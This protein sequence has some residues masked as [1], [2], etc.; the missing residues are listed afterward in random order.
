MAKAPPQI[1]SDRRRIARRR[2][3]LAMHEGVRF[4]L[5]EVADDMLERL[6]FVRHQPRR[7]LVVGDPAG[8]LGPRLGGEVMQADIAGPGAIALDQPLPAAGFDFIAVFGLLDTVNDLPGA[9]IHLRRALAPGGLA[10]ASFAGAGSL[11]LLRGAMFAAEP[12]RPAARMHPLVDAR[13]GAELLQRTGW[14]D[15]VSDMRELSVGYRT[16]LQLVA[17]LRAACLGNALASPAPPLGRAARARAE[18]AFMGGA[19]RVVE[20]FSILTLSGRSPA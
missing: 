19:E 12:D 16:M 7:S 18:A 13:A 5:E 9:L 1:F 20:T 8:A 14:A 2:R 10:I 17:D 15:P 6:A 3:A 4:L 11:P